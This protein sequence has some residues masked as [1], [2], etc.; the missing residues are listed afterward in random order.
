M[1]ERASYVEANIVLLQLKFEY[2]VF[3]LFSI[4]VFLSD[5][6]SHQ[7]SIK[8]RKTVCESQTIVN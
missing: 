5:V 8:D 7:E 2:Y 1:Y 4:I 3:N 6:V